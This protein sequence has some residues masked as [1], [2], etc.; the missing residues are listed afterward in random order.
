MKKIHAVSDNDLDGLIENLGLVESLEK[1]LLFCSYCGKKLSRENIG[2]I[3]PLENEIRLCCDTLSCLEKTLEEMT[4]M[5]RLSNRG[6]KGN[7]S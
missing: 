6:E 2:C 7:E 3:Y 5:R 1:E 4:P